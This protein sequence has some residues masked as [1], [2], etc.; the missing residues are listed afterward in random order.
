MRRAGLGRRDRMM[1]CLL[2]NTTCTNCTGALRSKGAHQG[3]AHADC[4]DEGTLRGLMGLV[5]GQ[6]SLAKRWRN[7]V[8]QLAETRQI[9]DRTPSPDFPGR[10]NF[11]T[12]RRQ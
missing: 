3:S 5:A 6:L 2:L 11:P 9:V 1:G 12:L 7:M 10:Q 4:L 8:I